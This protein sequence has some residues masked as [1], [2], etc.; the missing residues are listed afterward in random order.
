MLDHQN[1]SHARAGNTQ[2]LNQIIITFEYSRN[3]LKIMKYPKTITY[4]FGSFRKSFPNVMN[5]V[6]FGQI[7]LCNLSK[8]TSWSSIRATKVETLSS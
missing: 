2:N 4:T 6:C 7:E 8:T 5:Q 1:T 3:Q